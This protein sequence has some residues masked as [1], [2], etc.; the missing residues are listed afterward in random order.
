[1]EVDGLWIDECTTYTNIL[2][3][4]VHCF[5]LMPRCHH[6][7]IFSKHYSKL[8]SSSFYPSPF[9]V[10]FSLP[11]KKDATMMQHFTFEKILIAQNENHYNTKK[12]T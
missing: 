4:R 6:K 11:N 12:L 10:A 1:M 7:L 5:N 9:S 2:V 3:S 8:S